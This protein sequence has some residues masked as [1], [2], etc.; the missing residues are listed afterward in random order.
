LIGAV[1]HNWMEF[2]ENLFFLF[3]SSSSLEKKKKKK[4]ER[5]D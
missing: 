4:R 5:K 2:S 1:D 3:S